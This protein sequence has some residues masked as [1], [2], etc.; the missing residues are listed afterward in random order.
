[1]IGLAVFF[2]G[3]GPDE[4]DLRLEQRHGY[5]VNPSFVRED[6]EQPRSD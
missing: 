3:T 5:L 1:V 6:N 4:V 2:F